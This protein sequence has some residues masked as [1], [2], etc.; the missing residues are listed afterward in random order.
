M[1]VHK[2]SAS[3]EQ[4]GAYLPFSSF[5]PGTVEPIGN[6]PDTT[7]LVGGRI[8]VVTARSG[9]G[10]N[11]NARMREMIRMDESGQILTRMPLD[12]PTEQMFITGDGV[13]YGAQGNGAVYRYSPVTLRWD[14]MTRP[15]TRH[16]LFGT[17]G[18]DLVYRTDNL[19]NV[20]MSWYP[21]PV[22]ESASYSPK[23]W[24]TTLR[25]CGSERCSKT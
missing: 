17:D 9:A 24:T 8:V 14:H 1:L 13:L 11:T 23:R 15:T 12:R 22:G 19:G 7:I 21:Q 4:I 20:V 16:W 5:P 18:S 25:D 10:S 2:Y 3:G 6:G